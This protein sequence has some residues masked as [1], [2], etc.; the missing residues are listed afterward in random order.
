[1]HF[2]GRAVFYRSIRGSLIRICCIA[3]R[4]SGVLRGLASGSLNRNHGF[5][6][7][8]LHA[9]ID[10]VWIGAGPLPV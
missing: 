2:E 7:N 3:Q 1:M 10:S 6:T 9:G 8:S 5:I 4:T